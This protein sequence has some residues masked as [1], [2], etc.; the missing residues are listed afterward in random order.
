MTRDGRENIFAFNLHSDL[1]RDRAA[2]DQRTP[3]S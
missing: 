3:M 1:Y 2:L